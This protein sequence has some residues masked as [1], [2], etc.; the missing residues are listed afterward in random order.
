M[1]ALTGVITA[2]HP[3]DNCVWQIDSIDHFSPFAESLAAYAVE[4]NRCIVYFRFARHEPV[5]VKSGTVKVFEIDPNEGFE[6]FT[7]KLRKIISKYAMKA[8][9]VFDCLSD[10]QAYWFSDLMLGNFYLLICPYIL[11][12]RSLAFFPIWRNHHSIAV[13]RQIRDTT[14]ILIDLFLYQGA[15]HIYPIKVENRH[16]PTMFLP[17]RWTG[18]RFE[19]LRESAK[20]AQMTSSVHEAG[21][22]TPARSLDVWDRIFLESADRYRD[23]SPGET[24]NGELRDIFHRLAG[25]IL[26]AQDRMRT[27]I[28]TY[29]TIED[30][31]A[32]K[33]RMIGSG[34]IGGKSLGMILA[35]AVLKAS[36][37]SWAT[38]LEDHDSFYIGSDVFYT[39]IVRNDCWE[40][41]QKQREPNSFLDDIDAARE[42]IMSGRFP[43]S[44]LD[45]FRELLDYFGQAPIIVRSSS[46]LEDSFGN[47]FSGKYESVFCMNQGDPDD[48]LEEFLRAVKTV[49]AS[50]MSHE[51]LLYRQNRG[52]LDRDEQMALLVQRVS[53][54]V[55][56]RVYIP[57]AAGVGL[58]FNP[59]VWST[60]IEP[61]AGLIRLVCGLGTRAVNRHDDDYTRIVALNNPDLAPE[62]SFS[63]LG[64]FSQRNV[65]VL[66]LEANSFASM[67]FTTL[68]QVAEGYPADFVSTPIEPQEPGGEPVRILTFDRLI[69]G[70]AFI[71]TMR[72]LMATL[73]EAYQNPV[74]VE[75][76]VNLDG[77]GKFR[78]NLVQCRPLQTSVNGTVLDMPLLTAPDPEKII[79]ET[80]GAI[81]GRNTIMRLDQIIYIDPEGYSALGEQDRHYVARLIGRLTHLNQNR[82]K[83]IML[84]GPG[85]W[86]TSMASLGIPVKF[87]EINTVSVLCEIVEMR[88]N[89]VPDVSLGTHFFNDIVETDMLYIA[90]HPRKPGNTLNTEYLG[91]TMNVFE[92]LLPRESRYGPII[93]VIDRES[94]PIKTRFIL[95]A[96]SLRQ[97]ARLFLN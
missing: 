19:P 47:A 90:V 70:T 18:S 74:D 41:R 39:Y 17:H 78:I 93:R 10:L 11:H 73:Q 85:R 50:T 56:G 82:G 71:S 22:A 53:G 31:L 97:H 32:I 30:L 77:D 57:A 79:L 12:L 40:F 62:H 35:R 48:R 20:I 42:K 7:V 80:R 65:D 44:T 3:G 29:L 68:M 96:D 38:V 76:T 8:Y 36:D 26:T 45:R 72:S 4:R 58:S 25:M 75:F 28:D 34:R 59:Y 84:I 23:L 16:S 63:Q 69:H 21:I 86:G 92:S 67:T 2:F 1:D 52:L 60:K 89:L 54:A 83:H 27:L 95:Y 5:L 15:T 66:D 14:Q 88:P 9:F 61:E 94:L 64:R 51:A 46:L 55:Y 37:N 43:V 49:Y 91:S 6:T 24:G 81:I 87:A 33:D 13:T